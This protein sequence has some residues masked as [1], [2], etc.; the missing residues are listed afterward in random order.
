MTHIVVLDYGHGGSKS[1]A[2]Y[3]SAVEKQLNLWTGREI[4]NELH[5][6]SNGRNVSV[7]LTRDDDYDVPLGVRCQLVN[8]CAENHDVSL[9]VSVH[10]N[11]ASVESAKGFE[12]FY[13]AG[14]KEGK[15]A[16]EAVVNAAE[17]G[18]ISIRG[19]GAKTTEQLGRK[20]AFIHKIRSPS[21]LLEV[22]YLTN[23][24]DRTN[25]LA[26][27]F[28]KQVAKQVA[29]G[30]WD[31]LESLHSSNLILAQTGEENVVT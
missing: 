5:R 20:L 14:S 9:A 4:Y 3:G 28:R 13:H 15:L 12:I 11:A 25:A 1:G 10:Y 17:S 23:F 29:R 30:V 27:G 18:G 19:S 16:A 21:I 6:Q 2:I 24:R 8:L 31:F 7:L 22:G 26:P